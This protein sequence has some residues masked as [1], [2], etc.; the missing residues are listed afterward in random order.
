MIK[1]VPHMDYYSHCDG[2]G[3]FI[4]KTTDYHFEQW[5]ENKKQEYCCNCTHIRIKEFIKELKENGIRELIRIAFNS[6]YS[7]DSEELLK[8]FLQNSGFSI[9][10]DL[11]ASIKEY[12]DRFSEEER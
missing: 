8:E 1:E 4:G 9:P 2:C 7:H 11:I 3:T 5:K 10:D 12:K 6:L